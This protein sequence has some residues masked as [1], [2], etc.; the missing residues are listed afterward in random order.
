[1]SNPENEKK[2]TLESYFQKKYEDT[3][4]KQKMIDPSLERRKAYRVNWSLQLKLMG[5]NS[6]IVIITSAI[7]IVLATHFFIADSEVYIREENF[8]LV[9]LV[10]I[11]VKNFMSSTILKSKQMAHVLDGRPSV[12][13][14]KFTNLFFQHDSD[15]LFIGLYKLKN[16][17]LNL[18]NSIAKEEYL[19]QNK[20]NDSFF[21]D[22]VSKS[23][24][25]K[26]KALTGSVAIIN[27]NQKA[28]DIPYLG[29]VIPYS[30][31]KY[32]TKVIVTIIGIENLITSFSQR[33]LS[34]TFMI[35]LNGNVL[36]HPEKE[37][38]LFVSN[39]I[40]LPIVQEMLKSPIGNGQ[41][42]YSDGEKY[43]IG[44]FKKI[45]SI[46]GG[47]ISNVPEEKV[48]EAIYNIQRRNIYIS[49]ISV[50]TSMIVMFLFARTISKPIISLLSQTHKLSHG[51]FKVDIVPTTQDEVGLLTKYFIQ[52]SKGLE[53]RE[54]VK[55]ALGRFVNPAVVNLVINNKLKLGG[56]NRTSAILFSD[57]RN[58]TSIC[59]NLS[60]EEVVE[61]LNEYL[62]FMVSCVELTFGVVD[63]FI[64]D[65][66]V[67]TWGAVDTL[68]NPAENAINS[69]LMMR[70]QV[71]R[72]NAKRVKENKPPIQI[73]CGLN[74]GPV[75]AGQIGTLNHS[76][77]TVIGDT[78]NLASRV[79]T[80]TKS[81]G[82]DILI[83]ERMYQEVKD[84][85]VV[86]RMKEIFVKGKKEPQITYAII[87]RKDSTDLETPKNL[88]EVRNLMG[89]QFDETKY[90]TF[91]LKEEKYSLEE[92]SPND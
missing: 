2:E 77:Y 82:V 50:F 32:E 34:Q 35:D 1:M 36:V 64:G 23:K 13:K 51:D 14:K 47:I 7:I 19:S 39:M 20:I 65:A 15:I 38:V 3:V 81:F 89:I 58:F 10:G 30:K 63:K 79:E 11:T 61:F 48:F 78:V 8:K 29:I 37:K 67:A 71:L 92:E 21:K 66:I 85:Y 70:D 22:I 54:K 42:R 44:S 49:V 76:E 86:E 52:M 40:S 68:G 4:R 88:A 75:I 60:P 6:L 69:A 90:A 43:F 91:V 5:I 16:G 45:D 62:S 57:M 59:E 25:V 56:E 12:S 53:E 17:T 28:Q 24:L 27:I 41:K 31:T 83:T 33:G 74:F 80:L 9:D 18:S 46:N 72:F 26:D 84:I 73:G 87:T 55:D